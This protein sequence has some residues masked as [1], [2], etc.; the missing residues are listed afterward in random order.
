MGNMNDERLR[1]EHR[2][3]R[4]RTITPAFTYVTNP[5]AA[6]RFRTRAL[7]LAHDRGGRTGCA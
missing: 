1:D 7:P 2:A 3:S 6:Y 4:T 5:L